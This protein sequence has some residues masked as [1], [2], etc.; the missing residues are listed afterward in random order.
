MFQYFIDAFYYRA[1]ETDGAQ[2]GP[3][4]IKKQLRNN[5]LESLTYIVQNDAD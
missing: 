2:D 5:L 4:D 1:V 3:D